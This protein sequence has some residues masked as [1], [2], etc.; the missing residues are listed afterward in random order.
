MQEWGCC[1]NIV[2]GHCLDALPPRV[3]AQL[4]RAHARARAA[5]KHLQGDIGF[6]GAALGLS[7]TGLAV[8][9]LL[10]ARSYNNNW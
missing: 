2:M 5:T 6:L 3:A 9:S 10:L 1:T 4:R 8:M 7:M